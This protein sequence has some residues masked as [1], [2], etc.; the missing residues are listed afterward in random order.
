MART[1]PILLDE[2]L[3]DRVLVDGSDDHL[4]TC[5]PVGAA[6]QACVR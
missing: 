6:V 2:P 3:G 4:L 5:E 1:D